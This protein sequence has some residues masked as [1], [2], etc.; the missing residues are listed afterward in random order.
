M[1]LENPKRCR[2]K[3]K[4]STMNPFNREEHS[5]R[6]D[7][8]LLYMTLENQFLIFQ[9]LEFMADEL[10]NLQD[11]AAKTLTVEEA[12]LALLT[13]QKAT[14]D[15]L[16]KQ[17]VDAIA[18][19]NPAALQAVADSLNTESDKVNAAIA[20]LQPATPAAAPETPAQ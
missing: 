12:V 10:K 13:S 16:S 11:A 18:A 7:R 8:E 20:A 1:G 2:P 15:S 5:N 3:G 9:K 6:L 17:L 4:L 14:I 19:G